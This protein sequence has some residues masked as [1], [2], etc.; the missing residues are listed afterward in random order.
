[1]NNTLPLCFGRIKHLNYEN[2]EEIPG[3]VITDSNISVLYLKRNLL[4]TL[5]STAYYSV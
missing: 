4:K 1:M 5:V 2:L 3:D